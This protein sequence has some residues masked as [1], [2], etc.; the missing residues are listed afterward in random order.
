MA[1]KLIGHQAKESPPIDKLRRDVPAGL[2]GVLRRMLAK[3]PEDRYQT[4]AQVADA[5]L[6]Y[7]SSSD[8]QE[9]GIHPGGWSV[10]ATASTTWQWL[11]L[12][13]R[14]NKAFTAAAATALVLLVWSSAVNY[15]ARRETEKSNQQLRE[16]R[17][18][19]LAAVPAM[20]DAARLAVDRQRFDNALAQVN[21]A[22]DYDP[23][24]AEARLLKAQVLIV[25]KEFAKAKEELARYLRQQ[26]KDR[27]AE[28]LLRLCGRER[29]GEEATLLE[30]AY[31]FEQEQK[32]PALAEGLL[33]PIAPS[34]FKAREK[35]LKLYQLRVE[36]MGKGLGEKLVMDAQG[37]YNLNLTYCNQI[38]SLEPLKGMPL[39]QLNLDQCVLVWDLAPLKGMPLTRLS[40]AYCPQVQ[41]LAAASR[42]EANDAGPSLLCPGARLA[43]LQGM[44]LTILNLYRCDLVRDLSPLD[45]M[46]LSEIWL[47]PEVARGM[48]ILRRMK[49]LDNIQAMPAGKFWKEYDAGKF[50]LY[51]Q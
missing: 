38:T 27:N 2:S 13:A 24:S 35:L 49:T 12:F 18:R 21:L 22:L 46:K 43:P 15:Q 40:L 8:A 25:H 26:P 20:I 36:R 23:K 44:P 28:R 50:P 11:R 4:P 48:N 7:I 41:D 51:K 5:I 33:K 32:M 37:I 30:L 45:G 34:S 6:P 3:Q 19:T 29:P 31:V 47:P 10:R 42:H 39:T 1:E 9:L 17:Q 14:R 16:E